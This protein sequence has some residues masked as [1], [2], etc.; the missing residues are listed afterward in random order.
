[1]PNLRVLDVTENA[2][3][4]EEE[5]DLKAKLADIWPRPP[6]DSSDEEEDSSDDEGI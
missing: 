6:E 5:E 2:M 4:D 1:M 3:N